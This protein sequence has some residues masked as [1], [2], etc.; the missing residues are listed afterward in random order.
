MSRDWE[1]GNGESVER[2]IGANVHAHVTSRLIGQK[3]HRVQT[4]PFPIPDSQF[5]IPRSY[6]CT[7]RISAANAIC[8][9]LGL[10]SRSALRSPLAAAES[11][12]SSKA[13]FITTS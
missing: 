4:A 1:I 9:W 10:V 8:S 13:V 2:A 3:R 7:P 5:P 12:N 6:Q 11:G